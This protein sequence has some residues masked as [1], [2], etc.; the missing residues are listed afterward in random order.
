MQVA[1]K[2][3][4]PLFGKLPYKLLDIENNRVDLLRRILVPTVEVLA[5]E[6]AAVVAV[7]DAVHVDHWYDLEDEVLAEDARFYGVADE[8]FDYAFHHPGGV[9]LAR[10]YSCTDEDTLLGK[11]LG[12]LRIL[13]LAG[14]RDHVAAI[15][16][17]CPTQSCPLKKALG[18]RVL[19]NPRQVI[20]KVCVSVWKAMSEKLGVVVHCNR[21][22]KCQCVEP[23][24][25]LDIAILLEAI[26]MVIDVL[27][28]TVPSH[29]LNVFD[30]CGV[31]QYLHSVVVER[32]GLG[33]IDN[34]EP[35]L[36]PL[37]RVPDAKKEP[38]SV[39]VRV[40]VILKD[41]V[42]LIISLFH[43]SQKVP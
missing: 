25:E 33:Q 21:V 6:R 42:I 26:L 37:L 29:T 38:L 43:H 11:S 30:F 15:A 35:H 4:F 19:L 34:I 40:N 41:E 12:T 13:V 14:D 7:D 27:T 23:P 20:L 39:T 28:N 3:A 8:E 18:R 16:S 17:Q 36:H 24:R 5:T 1:V 9:T 22:H 10:M 32:V 2:Y 31:A